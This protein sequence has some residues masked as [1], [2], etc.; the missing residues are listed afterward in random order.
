[1]TISSVSPIIQSTGITAPVYSDILN[2]FVTEY[3][4]I[5]GSDAVTT[6]DSKTGQLLSIIAAAQVD[7]NSA[8]IQAYNGFAPD[9]SMGSYLSSLVKINGLQ[10]LTASN[11]TAPIEVIGVAGSIINNGVVQDVNGNQWNLP[12]QVII[13]LSGSI[14][15]L[16]TAQNAGAIQ[17]PSGSINI[18]QNPTLG[19]QSATST[20]DADQ[21]NPVETDGDLRTR[22][23]ISTSFPALSTSDAILAGIQNIPGVSE[24]I[25][26]ENF[27]GT[28]DSNGIPG[29]S[30][31]VV[32]QG[33]DPIA[34]AGVIGN[35]KSPGTGTYGTTSENVLVAG[36]LMSINFFEA[37]DVQL[38]ATVTIHALTGY[39]AVIGNQIGVN[40][41]NYFST[42]GIGDDVYLTAAYGA[43]VQPEFH[44]ISCVFSISSGT[45]TI[46]GSGNVI[47]PFNGL[48]QINP[49]NVTVVLA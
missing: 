42:L 37:Q 44:L 43:M 22:Q 49:S 34:V 24:S 1:M 5:M 26:Y 8:V 20:A 11:S 6:P 36:N 48:A 41:S 23:T 31:S 38:T 15:V 17:A 32:V 12:T 40:L 30:I 45:A 19:W 10:R 18:I 16:G 27:T 2:Y 21:G 4:A 7:A 46:D 47:I 35:K 9:F 28:T 39:T 13:P 29:H 3:Q 14:T 33:G 25:I